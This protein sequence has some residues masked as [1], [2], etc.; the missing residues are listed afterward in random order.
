MPKIF[1][2]IMK[3]IHLNRLNSKI[4]D[5]EQHL[6]ILTQKEKQVIIQ[7]EKELSKN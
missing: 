5:Y 4:K 6:S 7:L 3:K 1:T 2:Y